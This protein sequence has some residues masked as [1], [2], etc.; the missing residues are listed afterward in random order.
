ML[1]GGDLHEADPLCWFQSAVIDQARVPRTSVLERS[2]ITSAGIQG[3]CRWLPPEVCPSRRPWGVLIPGKWP[4]SIFCVWVYFMP[5]GD[6][7]SELV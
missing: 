2:S 7:K 3:C 1:P 5:G 6:L 4:H